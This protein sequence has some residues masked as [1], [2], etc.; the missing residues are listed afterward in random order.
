M[1]T[2]AAANNIKPKRPTG[3]HAHMPAV[4]ASAPSAVVTAAQAALVTAAVVP[5]SDKA[6]LL[7]EISPL[8]GPSKTKARALLMDWSWE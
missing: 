1:R 3:P 8:D 5:G 2:G 7:N 4:N 6:S